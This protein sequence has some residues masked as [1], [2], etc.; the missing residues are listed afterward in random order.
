MEVCSPDHNILSLQTYVRV[1]TQQ[2]VHNGHNAVL[3]N[4][5]EIALRKRLHC[6]VPPCAHPSV[7]VCVYIPLH[8][9]T[10]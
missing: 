3:Q 9:S 6:T 5:R 2:L 4:I 10:M 8:L 7:A 1:Y